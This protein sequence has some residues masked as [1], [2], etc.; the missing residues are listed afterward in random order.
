MGPDAKGG[1]RTA[2][3]HYIFSHPRTDLGPEF[4]HEAAWT[5]FDCANRVSRIL[6]AEIHP[7]E[8]D[9]HRQVND[10]PAWETP[11]PNTVGEDALRAMCEPDYAR[12]AATSQSFEQLHARF[13]MEVAEHN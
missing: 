3:V 4:V 11:R 7:I 8:G 12:R 9:V 5:E 10:A 6:S 1:N 13:L 2:N